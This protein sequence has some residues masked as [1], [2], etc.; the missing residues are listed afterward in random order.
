MITKS[1]NYTAVPTTKEQDTNTDC[2]RWLN[3]RIVALEGRNEITYF[4]GHR[5]TTVYVQDEANPEAVQQEQQ[6][7]EAFAF[8]VKKPVSRDAA[9]NAAEMEAYNLTSAMSV[10]SFTA[11]M[12]RKY[13][14]NPDD[15]EVKEHDEFIAWVKDELTRIGI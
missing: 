10:A 4:I 1:L 2:S 15:A 7:T 6:A 11:S 5:T 12:A 9:I 14:D 8:T 13:R 3:G